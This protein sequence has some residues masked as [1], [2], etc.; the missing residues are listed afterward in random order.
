M[1]GV[2][3]N[4][5]P[6]D[7]HHQIGAIERR[8]AIFRLVVEKLID[9]N[10]VTN[11]EQLDLC[12]ST[13]IGAVNTSIHTRGRSSMQAVFGKRPRYPGDLFSDCTAL[14]SSDFHML[15]EQ[16]RSQACQAV[17]EMSASSVIRRA[18]LRKTATSRAKINE[19]LPGSL[20]AY[21]R[22]NL[23][24]RGRKRGGYILGRL[25]VK[26]DKNAWVRSGSSLVQVTHE[27]PKR[28]C[29]APMMYGC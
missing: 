10:G 14:A 8:N 28:G 1:S 21:W 15:P 23:K 22:W 17:Q 13:A 19:L 12:L 3:L 16:L 26:D 5:V 6:A 11:K 25:V 29:L 24:A 9:Q 18:L 27:Q 4:V 20:V 7:G 2:V